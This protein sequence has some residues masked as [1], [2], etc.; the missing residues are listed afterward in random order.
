MNSIAAQQSDPVTKDANLAARALCE[1]VTGNR[2]GRGR[3]VSAAGFVVDFQ[4]LAGRRHDDTVCETV[5]GRHLPVE[6]VERLL[7]DSVLRRIV[8]DD[9]GVPINVG[10]RYRTATDAQWAATKAIYSTCGWDCCD[11]PISWCQLHHIHEWESGGATDLRN[12]VPLCGHHHHLV[13]EGGWSIR[14]L[15]ARR[16]EIRRPDGT[17]HALTPTPT[18]KVVQRE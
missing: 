14:L 2:G 13:H 7:C 16:L 17:L 1:L 15:D 3:P 10:R 5:D 6:S 4:T 8:L 9:R 11:R 18:R 12:L